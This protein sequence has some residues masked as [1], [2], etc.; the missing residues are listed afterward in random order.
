LERVRDP[1]WQLRD[2]VCYF[3]NLAADLQQWLPHGSIDPEVLPPVREEWAAMMA[4]LDT[5]APISPIPAIPLPPRPARP[6][7]S[8]RNS[9][10]RTSDDEI[11]F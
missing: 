9:Q 11:P 5:R 1:A 2:L 10:D 3:M 4:A 6:H 7:V 8:R